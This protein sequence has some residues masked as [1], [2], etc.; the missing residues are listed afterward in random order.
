MFRQV[1]L[2]PQLF[3]PLP[4]RCPGTAADVL[5]L[6]LI[7]TESGLGAVG[8]FRKLLQALRLG[9]S[10]NQTSDFRSEYIFMSI[11]FPFLTALLRKVPSY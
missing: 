10:E 4:G 2:L 9:C 5:T 8:F 6:P 7:A 3:Q 1:R 11:T